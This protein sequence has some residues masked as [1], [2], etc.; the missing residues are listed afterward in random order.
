MTIKQWKYDD[1]DGADEMSAEPLL[2]TILGKVLHF[3]HISS[4]Y[5]PSH[6][7]C[8]PAVP[9]QDK[10]GVVA[11]KAFYVKKGDDGGGGTDSPDWVASRWIVGTSASVIFLCTIDRRH[12]QHWIIMNVT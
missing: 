3:V 5:D 4:V 9:S 12:F 10:L 11:E 2:N 1:V 8:K 7:V 6:W